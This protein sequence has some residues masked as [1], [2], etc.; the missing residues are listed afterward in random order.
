MA[1]AIEPVT[2]R[3]LGF[4]DLPAAIAI[5]AAAFELDLG[6][7]EAAERW[8]ARLSHPL[9]TDPDGGFVAERDGTVVGVAQAILRDGLW[10]LALLTI[11]PGDQSAGAG[12]ALLDRALAYGAP[13][14]AGMVVSSSDPRALR[15]YGRAGFALR[16]AFHALGRVDRTTLPPPDPRVRDA[17]PADLEALEAISREVRGGPHTPELEFAL[18]GGMS[19][20]RLGDRG[21]AVAD[22]AHGVWLLAARDE[23][24]ATALLWSA[25]A[26]I[27]DIEDAVV[28]WMT[29]EQD[30][31]IDVVLRAG[32]RPGPFGGLCARGEHGS[33]RPFLPSGAFA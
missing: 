15:L 29:G 25:L 18:N 17:G 21:F 5:S 22:P 4:D 12:R 6:D 30:W 24:A 8:H 14:R 9:R 7:A 10:V 19:L 32:L 16:P 28:R 27:E 23:E 3:P 11:D 1:A 31:A 20:M 33:L 26:A 2:I 13:A